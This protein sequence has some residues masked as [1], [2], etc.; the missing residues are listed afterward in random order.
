MPTLD[1][2]RVQTWAKNTKYANN[3]QADFS[4]Q[5]WSEKFSWKD[6]KKN[7]QSFL[8]ECG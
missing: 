7:C 4:T 1:S 3:F 5:K 6:L 2:N 8:S